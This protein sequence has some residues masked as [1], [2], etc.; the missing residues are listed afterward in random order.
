MPYCSC[1]PRPEHHLQVM[2]FTASCSCPSASFP[3]IFSPSPVPFLDLAKR[4]VIGDLRPAGQWGFLWWE[5]RMLGVMIAIGMRNRHRGWQVSL[6]L[7]TKWLA[8]EDL[9][10]FGRIQGLMSSSQGSLSFCDLLAET[11][12]CP[13]DPAAQG[14]WDYFLLHRLTF[15]FIPCTCQVRLYLWF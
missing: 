10:E 7:A 14:F 9:R 8:D 5:R 3:L 4:L 13:L 2:S 11:T 6:K 15:S 1:Q 12:H